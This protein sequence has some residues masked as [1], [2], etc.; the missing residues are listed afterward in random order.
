MRILGIHG[1]LRKGSYNQALLEAA[2]GLLP[3]EVELEV[4]GLHGIPLYDADV[5]AQGQPEPVLALKE[6]VLRADALLIATPEYNASLPG[7]LKNGIDW[8]SRPP[9]D[10]PRLFG[11]RTVGLIGASTG[12][13]ATQLAQAAWLPV[14]RVLG[15][16]LW[17]GGQFNM[18]SAHQKFDATGRLIDEDS[19]ARLQKFLSGFVAFAARIPSRRT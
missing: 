14:F 5:D 4:A 1:S 12:L 3:D 13:R 6:K 11:D 18:A 19:R 10:I 8:L 17:T 9:A 15:L 7:V 2:R 16:V